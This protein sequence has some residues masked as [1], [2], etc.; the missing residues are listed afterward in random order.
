MSNTLQITPLG[1]HIGAEVSGIQLAE[2]LSQLHFE[3]LHQALLSH[4]VLFFRDQP[5]TPLAQRA[6]A[7]R[8]GDLHIHP[9]YPHA[10]EAEEIIVLDTTMRIRRT[11]TTG[12]PM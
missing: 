1:P 11:T 4:Q 5:I 8:F 12:I 3:Q 7:N 6:L 10:P 2:P 9:V